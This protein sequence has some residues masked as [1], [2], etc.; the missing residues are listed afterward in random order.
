MPLFRRRPF[1]RI[2]ATQKT[3]VYTRRPAIVT[4]PQLE[5]EG[6]KSDG[7]GRELGFVKDIRCLLRKLVDHFG[8]TCR[9]PCSRTA[10]FLSQFNPNLHS[11]A[12]L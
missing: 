3:L 10:D 7:L 11:T 5:R 1:D 9:L 6:K 2:G 4:R 12:F 8:S